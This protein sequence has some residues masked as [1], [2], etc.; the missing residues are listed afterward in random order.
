[1]SVDM[2]HRTLGLAPMVIG[3]AHLLIDD[4][5]IYVE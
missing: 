2:P 4:V 5:E 1:L 3:E